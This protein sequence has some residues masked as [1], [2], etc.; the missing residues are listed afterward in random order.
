MTFRLRSSRY[1][2]ACGIITFA[3]LSARAN[4]TITLTPMIN[5]PLAT[6]CVTCSG[7]SQQ[8]CL[9]VP[10]GTPVPVTL[11]ITNTG[12]TTAT[13]AFF[14]LTVPSGSVSGFV[15]PPGASCTTVPLAPSS[16]N[17]QCFGLPP[18]A[19]AATFTFSFTFTPPTLPTGF[20]V[21]IGQPAGV[22]PPPDLPGT[23][24]VSFAPP[25]VPALMGTWLAALAL[26][27]AAVALVR[28]R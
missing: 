22:P 28:L 7:G 9:S 26:L 16:Q 25:P 19:S 20:G 13:P 17:F 15:A 24:C 4:A 2:A 21:T 5:A 18:L 6:N 10:A 3:L 11:I 1:L 8:S 23:A 14:L 27:F 12:P